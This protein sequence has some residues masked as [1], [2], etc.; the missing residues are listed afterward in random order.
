MEIGPVVI[1]PRALDSGQKKGILKYLRNRV[2]L[3]RA[4]P[5][6]AM[7]SLPQQH[8]EKLV[9]AADMLKTTAK[10]GIAEGKHKERQYTETHIKN[11][12]FSSIFAMMGIV[13]CGVVFGIAKNLL[14]IDEGIRLDIAPQD[15]AFIDHEDLNK[16]KE[17][18]FTRLAGLGALGAAGFSVGFIPLIKTL[19]GGRKKVYLENKISS[20]Y[21]IIVGAIEKQMEKEA[22]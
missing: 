18:A 22:D 15:A 2:L 3:D 20:A 5:V 7:V 4:P 8:H 11:I 9:I 13:L 12:C 16:F 1:T 21:E 19:I 6:D 10:A 14:E 17:F